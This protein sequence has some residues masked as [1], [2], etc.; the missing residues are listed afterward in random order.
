[1][2][3]RWKKCEMNI[4]CIT[5]DYGRFKDTYITFEKLRN[6]FYDSFIEENMLNDL[7]H[8]VENEFFNFCIFNE[9]FE[10]N[11]SNRLI[12]EDKLNEFNEMINKKWSSKIDKYRKRIRNIKINYLIR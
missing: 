5:S 4:T 9:W 11:D 12:N 6:M 2:S 7:K 10:G 3:I 1:M 8:F